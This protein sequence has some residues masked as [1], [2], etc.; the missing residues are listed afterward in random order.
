MDAPTGRPLLGRLLTPGPRAL[1][2]VLFVLASYGATNIL[3][4]GRIFA[5]PRERLAARSPFLGHWVRCHMCLGVPIGVLWALL[6][7]GP[8]TSLGAPVE[9]AAAGAVSSGACW[10]LRVA[11]HE[12]GG[13]TL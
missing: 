13:D 11:T 6:G 1:D 12:M 3:A 7:L 9:L 8:G 5:G 10:L 2:L 4:S